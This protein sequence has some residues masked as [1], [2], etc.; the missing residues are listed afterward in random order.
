MN[1]ANI[2]NRYYG[3]YLASFLVEDKR[4]GVLSVLKYI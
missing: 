4:V 1:G 3:D 2:G